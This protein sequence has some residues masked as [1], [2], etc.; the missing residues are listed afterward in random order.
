MVSIRDV[1]G[2]LLTPAFSSSFSIVFFFIQSSPSVDDD[3]FTLFY[4]KFRTNAP[5]IRSLMEQIEQRVDLTPE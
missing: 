3:A 5:R 2:A 1:L 4:G